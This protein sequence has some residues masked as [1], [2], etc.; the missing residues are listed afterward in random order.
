VRAC[1]FLG[2]CAYL[3]V[4]VYTPCVTIAAQKCVIMDSN[5][6]ALLE[7]EKRDTCSGELGK[8]LN[9]TIDGELQLRL[10]HEGLHRGLQH[11]NSQKRQCPSIYTMKSHYIYR[12]C[13][14]FLPGQRFPLRR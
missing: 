9:E 5:A 1:L 8:L 13:G 10:L 4:R 14:K 12:T 2:V 6:K 3:G 11:S 7:R